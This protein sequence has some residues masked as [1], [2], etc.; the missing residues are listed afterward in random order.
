MSMALKFTIISLASSI[1]LSRNRSRMASKSS[2]TINQRTL[3]HLS[4]A[5][6]SGSAV[7]TAFLAWESIVNLIFEVMLL[8]K[9]GVPVSS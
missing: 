1:T 6:T 8:L 9:I 5:I 2:E 7:I 3:H 4:G